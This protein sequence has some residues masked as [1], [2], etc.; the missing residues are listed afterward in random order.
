VP[1]PNEKDGSSLRGRGER[2]KVRIE[3]KQEVKTE[4]FLKLN[5]KIEGQKKHILV[6]KRFF[7]YKN[8]LVNSVIV[9]Q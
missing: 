9:S 1:G 6:K 5:P 4:K 3:V 2:R 8:G 7:K